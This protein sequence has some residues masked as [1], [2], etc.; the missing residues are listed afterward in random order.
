MV[1]SPTEYLDSLIPA[2]SQAFKDAI[3]VERDDRPERCLLEMSG[4]YG[5]YRIRLLEIVSPHTS[6]KYVY[7]V[8]DGEHVV[9]GFDNTPDVQALKLK[10]GAKYTDYRSERIPHLHTENKTR[11]SLT[12]EMTLVS[13]IAWLYANI[14]IPSE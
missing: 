3:V 7:Y 4:R 1:S 11:V 10:Y 8:L 13:F 6:R 12:D 2:F 14:A 5:Q 9:A